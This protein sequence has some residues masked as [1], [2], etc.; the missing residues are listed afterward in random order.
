MIYS[1]KQRELI[2]NFGIKYFAPFTTLFVLLAL[3]HEIAKVHNKLYHYIFIVN[4]VNEH[5]WI[6][7]FGA[8]TK[9]TSFRVI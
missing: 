3:T 6:I 2:N 8:R 4:T 5:I 1:S 7:S 9:K